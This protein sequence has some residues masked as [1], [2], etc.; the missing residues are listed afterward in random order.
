MMKYI[1]VVLFLCVAITAL[2]FTG[3]GQAAQI[4]N[5]SKINLS[6]GKHIL[7]A[8]LADNS[9]ARRLAELLSQAPLTVNMSDYGGMEKVGPLGT[10][11]PR[12][13]EHMTTGPGDLILYQGNSFVIYY[14]RNSWS[15]TRLGKIDNITQDELKNILGNGDVTVTL[16]LN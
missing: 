10:N 1:I 16:S 12:N 7:T 15:L 13:D 5:V 11:L 2:S 8:T 9:S 3:R 14:D 6:V 4:M